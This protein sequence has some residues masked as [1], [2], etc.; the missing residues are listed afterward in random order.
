MHKLSPVLSLDSIEPA[1][2][3][4]F[5]PNFSNSFWGFFQ[6]VIRPSR[7]VLQNMW[8]SQLHQQLGHAHDGTGPFCSP[9]L[10]SSFFGEEDTVYIYIYKNIIEYSILMNVI[11]DDIAL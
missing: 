10:H 4:V 2:L 1:V 6:Q 7:W 8:P 3:A 5:F 9:M 11:Y